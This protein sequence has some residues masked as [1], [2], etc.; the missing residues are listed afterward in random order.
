MDMVFKKKVKS[1]VTFRKKL[2]LR[3]LRE[4]Q[5]KKEFPER[6]S[7]K[8]DGNE[9]RC[10][11]KRKFLDVASKVCGYTKGKPRHFEICW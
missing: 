11:L 5:A 8:Y 2:K 1:K 9:D 10:G 7:N 3:R 4:S 6:V